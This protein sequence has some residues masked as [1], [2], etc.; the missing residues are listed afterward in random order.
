MATLKTNRDALRHNHAELERRMAGHGVAYGIVT[1]LLCGNEALLAEVLA[2]NPREVMDARTGNLKAVRSLDPNARTVYIK[3][4]AP[5][6]AAEVVRWADVSLNTELATLEALDREAA[7]QGVVHGVIVMVEM[8]D[9]REGVMRERLLE[10]VGRALRFEHLRIEGLGTNFNCLNGTMP[11]EDKLW[12][13]GL[14][15]E[16]V[17]L[18]Y[19]VDLRWVSGGTSV[20]LPMLFDG[21]VP[22]AVNHFRIGEGL[23]FGRDLRAGRT[24]EGMRDDVFELEAEVIEVAEKPSE[25]SGPFGEDPF[26]GRRDAATGPI[27]TARRAILDVGWLDLDPEFLEP[28]EDDVEIVDV[29]S[30]MTV[31]DVGSRGEPT[32]VGDKLRFKLRYMGALK[33]LNSDYIDKVVVDDD[34]RTVPTRDEEERRAEPGA[35]PTE[36]VAA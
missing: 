34:G 27:G 20:A 16:L 30:D 26:G 22:S 24:F 35:E 15:R 4:P 32:R 17:E 19:G 5:G 9:L 36:V 7:L 25:P 28:M 13:L 21:Q 23:F 29:S 2:L 8:G 3:P 14:F 33:L 12:Q 1:K 10:W 18:R 31:V 6:N 11:S